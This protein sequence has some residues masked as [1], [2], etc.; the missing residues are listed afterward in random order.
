[1][2]DTKK[3]TTAIGGVPEPSQTA[4]DAIAEHVKMGHSVFDPRTGSNL[5]G[6]RNVAVVAAPEHSAVF[7]RTIT[8][9]DH[10]QFVGANHALFTKHRE[11]AILSKRDPITG[12][13][14][15]HV[16]GLTPSKIAAID[17]ARH[18]GESHV[19]DLAKGEKI[20]SGAAGEHQMSHIDIDQRF[21]HLRKSAPVR[22]PYSG[23]HFSDKKLDRIDGARRGEPG[24]AD[25]ARV[26]L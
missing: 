11:S 20:P 14:S 5:A 19:Y 9:Q 25:A 1:M 4:Q 10:D 23:T 2:A 18:V 8:A 3:I 13:E 26:H 7:A 24:H 22:E 17:V 15:L 12:H 6:T 21:D 16:A